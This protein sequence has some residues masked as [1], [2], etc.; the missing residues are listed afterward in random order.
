ML[1][2]LA[3]VGLAAA[4]DWGVLPAVDPRYA[5]PVECAALTDPAQRYPQGFAFT[6]DVAIFTL[7][8]S[9]R[10]TNSAATGR[11]RVDDAAMALR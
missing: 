3:H 7:A 10:G 2:V 11:R 1:R 5:Q 4:V 6:S 8:L 9:R